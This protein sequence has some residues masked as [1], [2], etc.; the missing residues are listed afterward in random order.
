MKF[1]EKYIGSKK[2]RL[3]IILF[4]AVCLIL[5][6]PMIVILEGDTGSVIVGTGDTAVGTDT[7]AG[8]GTGSGT[9]TGSASVSSSEVYAGDTEDAEEAIT[10][11]PL[12][13]PLPVPV[14]IKAPSKAKAAIAIDAETGDIYSSKKAN[15]S[16]PVASVSKIMTV[17]LVMEKIDSG[18]GSLDSKVKIKNKKIENLSRGSGTGGYILKKGNTYTVKQLLQLTLISSSNAAAIQLGMWVSGSN[19][20]FIR[21]MNAEAKN[22]HLTKSSFT[23]ACGLNNSD[24]SIFGLKVR[25]GKSGTNMMSAAD[26]AELSRLLVEKY[27]DVLTTSSIKSVKVKGKKISSTNKLLTGNALSK[28]A[29]AYKIDGLKT[30][31]T[32]RAGSCLVATAMPDGKHRT[33]T[34][35]LNDSDKFEDAYNLIKN[36][37]KKNKIRTA[38]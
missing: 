31:Y 26:V 32:K 10:V 4:T 11:E 12:P 29:K 34:V 21:E 38:A 15:T 13:P 18:D 24:M 30:G 5:A 16:L 25:G 6:T 9:D 36:I 23:S 28:K 20:A 27:P 37:Y 14:K 17:W 3:T 19:K 1:I 7:G 2:I 33:I 8:A 22:L 35:I